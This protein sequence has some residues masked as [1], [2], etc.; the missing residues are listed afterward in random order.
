MT[1]MHPDMKYYAGDEYRAS[2]L[3]DWPDYE[4]PPKAPPT[5]ATA[6]CPRRPTDGTPQCGSSGWHPQAKLE[7]GE[8]VRHPPSGAPAGIPPSARCASRLN[9]Q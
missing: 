6:T 8:R 1:D 5:T 4:M 9:K 3:T 2:W 7:G